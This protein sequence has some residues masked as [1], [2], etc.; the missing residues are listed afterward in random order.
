[1]NIFILED[2]PD[3]YR[4]PKFKKQ[5]KNHKL[6]IASSVAKGRAILQNMLKRGIS[7]DMVFLDHDLNGE[8]YV[9]SKDEN[10]GVRIA[11][12]IRDTGIKAQVYIHSENEDGAR[13]IQAVLPEAEIVP[14]PH[15]I[16]HLDR[17][18]VL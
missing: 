6:Y 9:D 12:F 10:C 15:L 8:I 5:L 1:M 18:I 14:F 3:N 11:E 17:F 2:D 4:I 16:K 13:E 7:I